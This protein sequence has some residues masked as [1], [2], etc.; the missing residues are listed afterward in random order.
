[1]LRGQ[2]GQDQVVKSGSMNRDSAPIQLDVDVRNAKYLILEVNN[3]GGEGNWGDHFDWAKCLFHLSR[4][5]L[6]ASRDCFSRCVEDTFSL[7]HRHLLPP[8]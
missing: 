4:A 3:G 7:R 5:K 8:W 6:H 1:M 2:D